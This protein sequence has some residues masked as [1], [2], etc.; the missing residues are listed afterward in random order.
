MQVNEQNAREAF[1]AAGLTGQALE[2]AIAGLANMRTTAEVVVRVN[3]GENRKYGHVSLIK[4]QANGF[5][6]PVTGLR[7]EQIPGLIAQLQ[8]ALP[9]EDEQE[10][11]S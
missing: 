2:D 8:A 1:Q 5:E 4:I 11:A 6:K 9:D 7:F 3:E 10:D